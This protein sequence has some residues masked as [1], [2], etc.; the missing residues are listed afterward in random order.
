MLTWNS[1]WPPARGD[2]A[3]RTALWDP[4]PVFELQ[5]RFW[6]QFIE[7]NRSFW[8]LYTTALPQLGWPQPGVAEPP[9]ATESPAE[10]D[11]VSEAESVL[12]AQTRLWNH[13]LDA[14]RSLWSA[15]AWA[16]SNEPWAGVNEIATV[17]ESD[18]TPAKPKASRP[19]RRASAT[20]AK[21][22]PARKR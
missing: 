17:T 16:Q 6:N 13:F 7:A 14:N 12:E 8:S 22:R 15:T 5:T 2:D 11:V 20:G 1:M 18:T 9:A 21:S 4:T 19:A 10:P 3:G